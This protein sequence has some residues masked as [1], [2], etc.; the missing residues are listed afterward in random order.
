MTIDIGNGCVEC[1]RDTSPGTGLWVNRIPADNGQYD[2][3]L[4]PDCLAMECDICGD[5][6]LDYEMTGGGVVTCDECMPEEE[7]EC[8]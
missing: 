5:S 7:H 2:G 4:C 6:T 8:S 1:R 3:Y